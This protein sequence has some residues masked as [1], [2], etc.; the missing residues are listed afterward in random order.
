MTREIIEAQI[1]SAASEAVLFL[2]D[3]MRGTISYADGHT[4][5]RSSTAMTLLE[6][7]GYGLE[8]AL[9]S[10]GDEELVIT[11]IPD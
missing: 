10:T 8:P 2:T 11:V 4:H 7:A 3:L 1:L 9:H 6:L 5:L